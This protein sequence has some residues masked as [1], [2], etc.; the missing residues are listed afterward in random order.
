MPCLCSL[1]VDCGC[2]DGGDGVLDL[3][4]GDVHDA[5][6]RPPASLTGRLHATAL[7]TPLVIFRFC[8]RCLILS[9]LTGIRLVCTKFTFIVAFVAR[10]SLS[11]GSGICALGLDA[12]IFV[13]AARP[14]LA[15]RDWDHA[16]LQRILRCG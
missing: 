4:R 9:C 16:S 13:V 2:W 8:S 11:L 7:A 15:D 5:G 3:L 12:F 1:H 10:S 6:A 14:M